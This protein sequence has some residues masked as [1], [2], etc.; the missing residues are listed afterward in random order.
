MKTKKELAGLDYEIIIAEDGSKDGT[1]RIVTGLSGKRVT[2]LHHEKRLGKGGAISDA[3][4][5][6]KGEIVAFMDSDLS[7]DPAYLKR[8]MRGI[9]GGSSI[10]VGSRLKPGA[11]VQDA[12]SRKITRFAYNFLVRLI[13]RSSILDHQC[14]FK[15]F[16]KKDILPVLDEAKDSGFFWDTE[17]L[18][19]AQKRGLKIDEFPVKWKQGSTSRIDVPRDS[20]KLFAKILKMRFLH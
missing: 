4:K 3:I 11:Q 8:L 16:R 18:V 7:T 10:S 6:A 13:L 20:A 12:F 17:I 1:V 15:G 14:G 19:L 2:L 5:R 9:E